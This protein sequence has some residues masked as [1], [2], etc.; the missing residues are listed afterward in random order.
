MRVL[1]HIH[2]FNDA[3]IVEQ[4]IDALLLQTRPADSILIVD[5]ASSDETVER[6]SRRHV[7]ILR[8]AENLGTSGAVVT[9]FQFALES[10]YDWIWIL[11]ADSLPAP[12]ALEKLLELHASFSPR[13]QDETGFL[14]CLPYNARDGF[15]YHGGIFSRRGLAPVEPKPGERYYA[16]HTSLWS[17]ILYRL[18]AVR[19][20][21]LPNADYV[22]DWG[23]NEYGY[24]VMKAAYKGFIRQD[25]LLRHNV[26]GHNSLTTVEVQ[27][28]PVA[29]TFVEFPAIRCYYLVRNTFYFALYAATEGRLHLL[30]NYGVGMLLLIVKFILRPRHHGGQIRACLRGLWHG[31]T[32]NVAARYTNGH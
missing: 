18:A 9:G 20:I 11:D 14:A 5:N 12:D 24:R 7:S 27:I 2:T 23:E 22:L 31:V 16:C 3:D 8:N 6:A 28:G 26:R 21:G 25:A 29:V 19:R 4:A 32:G 10:N 17:G 1:A 13:L 30:T 15:L